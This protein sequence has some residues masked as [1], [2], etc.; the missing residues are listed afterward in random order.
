MRWWLPLAALLL[1][2]AGEAPPTLPPPLPP[3][4]AAFGGL[5]DDR[6]TWLQMPPSPCIRPQRASP[7]ATD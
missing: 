5:A 7:L 4:G 2:G 6:L 1:T 3:G